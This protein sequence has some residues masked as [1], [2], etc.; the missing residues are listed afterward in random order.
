V[1]EPL[2]GNKAWH[3]KAVLSVYLWS[4]ARNNC[5]VFGKKSSKVLPHG[6]RMTGRVV[7]LPSTSGGGAG[8]GGKSSN[9]SRRTRKEGAARGQSP[10]CS[11]GGEGQG[12]REGDGMVEEGGDE[13]GGFTCK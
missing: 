4:L 3:P 13:E 2:S 11:G 5:D 8:G 6:V 1:N 10:S 12:S 7:G 9:S